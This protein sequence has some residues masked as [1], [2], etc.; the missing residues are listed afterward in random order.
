MSVIFVL[1]PM[2]LLLG[3]GFAAGFAWMAASGQFDDL[4]TP[5]HRLLLEDS[6]GL[7]ASEDLEETE[8]NGT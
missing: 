1:L 5:A 8:R 3:A 7:E 4:E 2:A 6:T